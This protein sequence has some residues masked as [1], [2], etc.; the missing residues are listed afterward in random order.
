[1]T[2]L[3]VFSDKHPG[4]DFGYIE[5]ELEK[6]RLAEFYKNTEHTLK[7]W[8]G[9]EEPD[10]MSDRIT[11]TIFGSGSYGTHDTHVLSAAVKTAGEE[12]SETAIRKSLFLKR[13][14]PTYSAM[15]SRYKC[16]KD[17]PSLLPLMWAVRF[18]QIPFRRGSIR[19]NVDLAKIAEP[20]KVIAYRKE[21]EAVGL[22]FDFKE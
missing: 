9:G 13:M 18:L 2:D 20:D 5:R 14:F 21:L 7:V 6:L 12:S 22:K 11:N 8:F 19:R 4:L 10:N 15:A 1:M 3:Y 17:H 16:L